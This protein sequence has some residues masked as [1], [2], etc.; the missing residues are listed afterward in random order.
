MCTYSPEQLHQ[1]KYGSREVIVSLCS[2]VM[3]LHL[4][5]FI[6]VCGPQ[7]IGEGPEKGHKNN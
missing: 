4:E 2:A 5:Y 3:R 6:Q 7:G 1:N